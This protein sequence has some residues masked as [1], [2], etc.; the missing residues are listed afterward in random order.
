[1]KSGTRDEI[2]GAAKKLEGRVKEGLGK[3]LGNPGL[4]GRGNRER[5]EGEIQ[6]ERGELKQAIGR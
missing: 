6:K 5:L 4:E 3:A 2:E 1:M